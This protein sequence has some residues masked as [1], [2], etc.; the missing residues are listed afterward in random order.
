VSVSSSRL[1]SIVATVAC[2]LYLHFLEEEHSVNLK[3]IYIMSHYR[4][5]CS[6]V[7]VQQN[8]RRWQKH[9]TSGHT[10]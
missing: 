8:G 3:N 2:G 7:I 5:C 6:R 1:F 10:R 9:L 4:H